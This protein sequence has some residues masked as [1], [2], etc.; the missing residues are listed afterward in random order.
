LLCTLPS[1]A[2][3]V[4]G[5]HASVAVAVPSA[6]LI[7]PADGLH[8]R[9]SVVPP[10]ASAGGVT[11]AIH[12]TV[13]DAVDVLLHPSIASHVLVCEREHPL[14][15]TD[16]SL[17]DIVGAPQPSVAVAVPS[18]PLISPPDGL[19]PREVP[20]PPEVSPGGV[21]STTQV[22]VLDMVTWLLHPSLAVNVLV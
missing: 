18:A 2:A 21:T 20:V 17:T 15:D 11:S 12:V 8:P 13:L 14:L 6:L 5:P 16:P 19:Q 7:S 3:I 4:T 22:T 10:V 9:V 1:V